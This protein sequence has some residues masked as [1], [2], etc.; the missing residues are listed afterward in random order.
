MA[1]EKTI[2]EHDM[3]AAT[4]NVVQ[5]FRGDKGDGF[6]HVPDLF[7]GQNPVEP[8]EAAHLVGLPKAGHRLII[9]HVF[10]G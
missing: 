2:T 1:F 3:D 5:G 10:G 9:G 4:Q 7:V 8:L 6:P